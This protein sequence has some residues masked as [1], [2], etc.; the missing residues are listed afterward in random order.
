MTISKSQFKIIKSINQLNFGKEIKRHLIDCLMMNVAPSNQD[1]AIIKKI[2]AS[3]VNSW[4]AND[5]A[6]FKAINIALDA[7]SD[8]SIEYQARFLYIYTQYLSN[9][10]QLVKNSKNNDLY[11]FY[12]MMIAKYKSLL[13]K[14]QA[15]TDLRK[16][17]RSKSRANNVNN[18]LVKSILVARSSDTLK[19]INQDSTISFNTFWKLFP[20]AK[21][22]K[23]KC[24]KLFNTDFQIRRDFSAFTDYL[25]KNVDKLKQVDSYAYLTSF[26]RFPYISENER[27][28]ELIKI[29]QT[30]WIPI[31]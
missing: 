19:I 15:I 17:A 5:R 29:I 25:K 13:K 18:N 9:E 7:L 10:K 2:T 3:Y 6:G 21:T 1:K 30:P 4:A 22:K 24:R 11:N 16:K 28:N 8:S 20:G 31:N 23:S 12:K 26:N 27:N 14:E